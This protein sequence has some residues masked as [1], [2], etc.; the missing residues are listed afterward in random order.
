MLVLTIKK[1]WF[2]MILSREKKE[3]YREIKTYYETRFANVLFPKS[4]VT[5]DNV[6]LDYVSKF[7]NCK[8]FKAMFRNGYSKNSPSFIAKCTLS[9]GTGKEEWGAKKGKKYFILTIHEIVW[10]NKKEREI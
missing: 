7:P 3:D 6:F 2:D 1:K 9:V 4:E 5:M 8:E 10:E